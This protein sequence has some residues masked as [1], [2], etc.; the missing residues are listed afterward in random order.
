MLSNKEVLKNALVNI[1]GMFLTM[2]R[3]KLFR[4]QKMVIPSC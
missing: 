4:K 2:P 1:T 3:V